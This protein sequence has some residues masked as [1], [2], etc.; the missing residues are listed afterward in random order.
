MKIFL[1]A[2][3]LCLFS[4]NVYSDDRNT[5]VLR[6]YVP[7][8]ISTRVV[9]TQLSRS[10]SLVTFSSQMNS[11]FNEEQQKFEVEGLN[12]KGIESTLKKVTNGRVIQYE[13]LVNYLKDNMPT[14]KPIFLKI[15]AN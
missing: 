2:S 14:E 11:R 6:G 7:P 5:L 12:Q 8:S 13:L 3:L 10:Q 15:S 1:R 9:T 4:L